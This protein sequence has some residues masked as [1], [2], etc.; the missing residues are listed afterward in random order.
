[1]G[2]AHPLQDTVAALMVVASYQLR[3][4]QRMP[5]C[6]MSLG[7]HSATLQT[8]KEWLQRDAHPLVDGAIC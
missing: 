1:M 4:M 8:V 2:A 5:I 3:S 6:M 7:H